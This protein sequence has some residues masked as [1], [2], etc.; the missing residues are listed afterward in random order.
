MQLV[1]L[2]VG[3]A[4]LI[5]TPTLWIIDARDSRRYHAEQFVKAIRHR[6]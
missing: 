1:M 3:L 2:I 4:V 5:G 6:G